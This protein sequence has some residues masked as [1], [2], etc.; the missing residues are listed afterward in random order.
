MT[1]LTSVERSIDTAA[2]FSALHTVMTWLRN[3]LKWQKNR[4]AYRTLLE[5]DDARLND[6]GSHRRDILEVMHGGAS[7]NA[8]RAA[9]ARKQH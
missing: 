4:A 3:A 8:K 6:L 9:H 5:L 2:P 1:F 7:L